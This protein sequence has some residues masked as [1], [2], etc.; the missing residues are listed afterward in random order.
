MNWAIF[1]PVTTIKGEAEGMC[2]HRLPN[3]QEGRCGHVG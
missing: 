1:M 3:A 2:G